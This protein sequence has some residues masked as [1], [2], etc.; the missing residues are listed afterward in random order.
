MSHLGFI[1]N[2]MQALILKPWNRVRVRVIGLG[3]YSIGIILCM[4][5][6]EYNTKAIACNDKL[7]HDYL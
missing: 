5:F 1:D 6:P 7:S 2:S 4:Q 3:L